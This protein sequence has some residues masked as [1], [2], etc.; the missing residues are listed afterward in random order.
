MAKIT[1]DGLTKHF[2]EVRAVED[3][4]L[5]AEH[6]SFVALLGPSGCVK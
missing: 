6:G 4:N 5:V 2:G 3:L 1:L